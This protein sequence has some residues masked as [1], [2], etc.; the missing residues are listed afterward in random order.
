MSSRLLP[1]TEYE[2][3]VH[4]VYVD[5]VRS[6]PATTFITTCE[7]PQLIRELDSLRTKIIIVFYA[8]WST[9]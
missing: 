2:V 5:E 3:W 4:A 1:G 7:C 6:K 9:F 8:L